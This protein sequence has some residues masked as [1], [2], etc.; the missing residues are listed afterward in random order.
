MVWIQ[1]FPTSGTLISQSVQQIQDNWLFIQTNINFDHYFNSGT[2]NEGHHQFVQA[3]TQA[4]DVAPA[5]GAVPSAVPL[6][7]KNDL[8]GFP[9]LFTNTTKNGVRQVPG[10][11]SLTTPA[12]GANSTVGVYDFAG[13][14]NVKNGI[15]LIVSDGNP[16]DSAMAYFNYNGNVQIINST[17]GPHLNGFVGAGTQI[18]ISTKASFVPSIMYFSFIPMEF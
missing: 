18:Q 1:A 7:S 15:C 9:K 3:I 2:G 6:Y 13:R 8:S 14:E 10:F 16:N 4:G 5:V 12:I 11:V 17:V